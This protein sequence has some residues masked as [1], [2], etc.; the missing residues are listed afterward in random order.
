MLN[1]SN[2]PNSRVEVL[3]IPRGMVPTSPTMPIKLLNG[4][5]KL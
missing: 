2:T 5:F 4:K 3:V 1:S